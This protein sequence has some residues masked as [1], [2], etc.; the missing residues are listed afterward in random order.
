MKKLLLAGIAV[1]L[2]VLGLSVF[3]LKDLQDERTKGSS[4]PQMNS[5]PLRNDSLNHKNYQH[6][7]ATL[8]AIGD[9]LIHD[10]VYKDAFHNGKYD[11]D[12][13]LQPVKKLLQKPDLLIAN[14]ESMIGGTQIGL[15]NYPSFN[16][17]FEIADT[18]KRNGVDIVSISN[19]HSMDHGEKALYSAIGHYNQL[20]MPYTGAYKSLEDK[21][22]LRVLNRND[23]SFGFLSYT[24]GLNGNVLPKN[25]PY[26]VNIFDI[27]TVLED[28]K[29]ARNQVDVVVVSTHWGTEYER[30]P[31]KEQMKWADEMAKA[32]ADIIIGHHPHVLQPIQWIQHSGKKTLVVYSLGNFLSGQTHDYK[33]IGG[34]LTVKVNK[35]VT[36][37]TKEINLENYQ[38]TPTFVTSSK[39]KHYQVLPLKEAEEKGLV[40][41]PESYQETLAHMSAWTTE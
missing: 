19:N 18:L 12:P 15:S 29:H 16:S 32:G 10:R 22:R 35:T 26:L 27:H 33:D 6:T 1:L 40:Q 17:P 2:L 4:E 21:M 13:M 38:F 25:K 14:Q 7:S 28:I 36:N 8:G 39:Q 11:F 24:Y 41:K 3:L 23:I 5:L 9:V 30:M 34:I 37:K 20:G 31:S